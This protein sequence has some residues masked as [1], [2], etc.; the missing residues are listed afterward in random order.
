MGAA[1]ESLPV[2]V[3]A[4][5][6]VAEEL[7]KVAVRTGLDMGKARASRPDPLSILLEEIFRG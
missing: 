5:G 4:L 6:R 7:S 1:A 3:T 2:Q